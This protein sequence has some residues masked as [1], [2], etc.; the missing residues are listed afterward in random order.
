MAQGDRR[1]SQAEATAQELSFHY[2][3]VDFQ[4]CKQEESQTISENPE[5]PHLETGENQR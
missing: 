3:S 4:T 1:N 5:E 2:S